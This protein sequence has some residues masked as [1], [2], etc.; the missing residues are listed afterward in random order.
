MVLVF[1]KPP[2]IGR[3]KTRLARS[4][5][6]GVTARRIATMS[7]A[8]TL[9]ALRAGSW[10]VRLCLDP[11]HAR[12]GG[13]GR[14]ATGLE[15][16]DQGRGDLSA[17]L[18]K[19]L[20]GAPPGPVIFIGTDA[21]DLSGAL[22]RTAIRTLHT[23]DAVFGPARDGGF[24]LFGLNT[25]ARTASPFAPVRWSGPQALND[26]RANLPA[27]TRCALLPTLIDLDLAED[28]YDWRQRARRPIRETEAEA[29]QGQAFRPIP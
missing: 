21:P 11:G 16:H 1:A 23:H 3:S 26:V 6:S 20:A 27:G 15:I 25:S 7:L 22:I 24:Y 2:R 5:G 9:R 8:R 10:D 14:L 19:G 29:A 12:L 28:L 13:L 4:L 18:D 17:R